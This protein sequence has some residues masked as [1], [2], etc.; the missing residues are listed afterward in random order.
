MCTSIYVLRVE[1][2]AHTKKLVYT[3]YIELRIY[4]SLLFPSEDICFQ[5]TIKYIVCLTGTLVSVQ[6]MVDCSKQRIFLCA[7]CI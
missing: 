2:G 4:L 7:L 3:V 1:P 5:F 6:G